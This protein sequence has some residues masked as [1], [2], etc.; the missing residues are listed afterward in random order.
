MMEKKQ[1]ARKS[2]RAEKNRREE[3]KKKE[4]QSVLISVICGQNLFFA[5]LRVLRG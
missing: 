4:K 2:G 3:D 5:V 1:E